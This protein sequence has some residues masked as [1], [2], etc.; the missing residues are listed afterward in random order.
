VPVHRAVEALPQAA[1]AVPRGVPA[2]RHWGVLVSGLGEHRQAL[3]T[4]SPE[5]GGRVQSRWGEPGHQPVWL[6]QGAP[7][8]RPERQA[9]RGA[10]QVWSLAE[11]G[12]LAG[13]REQRVWPQPLRVLQGG[14]VP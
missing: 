12:L 11:P 8:V 9:V 10:R 14:P 7:A 5:Q 13:A 1:A 6:L 4:R 3:S 2:W